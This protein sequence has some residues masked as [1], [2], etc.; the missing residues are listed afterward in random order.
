MAASSQHTGFWED[1]ANGKLL[2]LYNGTEVAAFDGTGFSVAGATPNAQEST[3][4]DVSVTG[5]YATDD[6]PL[7]TAINALIAVLD[8]YGFTATS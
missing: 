5:T 6:T 1:K 4:A 7:E 8:Q 2:I 3:I